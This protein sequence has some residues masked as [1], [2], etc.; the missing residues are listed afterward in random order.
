MKVYCSVKNSPTSNR[1]VAELNA[2]V[3]TSTFKSTVG[4]QKADLYKD[5]HSSSKLVAHQTCPP[6]NAKFIGTYNITFN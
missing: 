2:S 6:V 5:P 3:L 4:V 1:I